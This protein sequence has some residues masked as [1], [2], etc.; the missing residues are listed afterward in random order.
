MSACTPLHR[1]PAGEDGGGGSD[2][3]SSPID[4]FISFGCSEAPQKLER[5]GADAVGA[6][7]KVEGCPRAEV[8][9]SRSC[10]RCQQRRR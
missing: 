9:A 2:M 6:V 8:P 4:Q 5:S 10:Q 7:R 3:K 1:F